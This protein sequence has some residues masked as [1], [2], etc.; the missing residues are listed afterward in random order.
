MLTTKSGSQYIASFQIPLTSLFAISYTTPELL[1]FDDSS[2]YTTFYTQ[3]QSDVKYAPKASP[4][5]TGNPTASTQATTDNSTKLATTAF[6]QNNV[7]NTPTT[8]V[9]FYCSAAGVL[10]VSGTGLYSVTLSSWTTGTYAFTFTGNVAGFPTIQCL[11]PSAS[12]N[13][14]ANLVAWTGTACTVIIKDSSNVLQNAPFWFTSL[15]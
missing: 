2:L 13:Y 15:Q 5:F 12:V 11:S 3:T 4:V 6:V 7:V 9:Q 8:R 14:N 1:T 10:T